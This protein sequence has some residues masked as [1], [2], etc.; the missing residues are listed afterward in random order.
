LIDEPIKAIGKISHDLK[1]QLQ[2]N[3][4]FFKEMEKG[5]KQNLDILHKMANSKKIDPS[6]RVLASI[7]AVDETGTMAVYSSYMETLSAVTSFSLV[8]DY[9]VSTIANELREIENTTVTKTDKEKLAK[10]QK[11]LGR[12]SKATKNMQPYVDQLREG[13]EKKNKWLNENR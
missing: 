6:V 13:I 12:L 2:V 7:I 5:T 3:N 8:M 11:E 9:C 10:L 1:A 4:T